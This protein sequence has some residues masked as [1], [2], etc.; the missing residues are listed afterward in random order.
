MRTLSLCFFLAV[1]LCNIA[2]TQN[3]IE[4]VKRS[5]SWETTTYE[6]NIF[7]GW[8]VDEVKGIMGVRDIK[9][10]SPFAARP[11]RM[12]LVPDEFDGRKQWPSC[13]HAVRNQ[14]NCGSC[15]AFGALGALSDRFCI[16]GK[17]VILSPQHLIECDK[18]NFC[19]EG[20]YLDKAFKFLEKE[21]TVDETCK[22]Y[23]M[24]C[25][26]CKP[27]KCTKFKC[28]KGSIVE[29]ADVEKTKKIISEDGPVEGAFIVYRDFLTY[30][31]GV[32][33]HKTG[34][35]LGGH[36]IEILG[37]GQEAGL[38]YWLCKNSWGLKWGME[39]YFKIKQGTC[40]ID[41]NMIACAPDL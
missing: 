31:S 3:F 6:E 8:T 12:A 27:E 32:Y 38:K 26:G 9:T 35:E 33:V 16:K 1:C 10:A 2:I 11:R 37:W 29:S 36:A 41:D 28:K 17:E 13:I 14:G 34:E 22:P 30:K 18:S 15:W 7:R 25:A 23:T 19:C 5:V 21:G 40:E 39:G 20:G 24:Q 4:E